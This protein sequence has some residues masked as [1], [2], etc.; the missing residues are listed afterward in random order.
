MVT[1]VNRAQMTTSTVGTGTITLG[2]A[3]DGF[4]SF[5]SAGVSD[6]DTVR[7]TI[8]DGS[9]WEIG[10]G[11]Y[12]ASGTT[13]TRVV[14]E[15]SNSGAAI[16]LSG[17]AVVF[18]TATAEDFTPS[19]TRDFVASGTLSDG[20]SVVVNTDGTVSV[21]SADAVSDTEV[22][23]AV[24]YQ[25]GM[26]MDTSAAFDPVNQKVVI[27]YQNSSNSL[28]G[29]AV[30]GTVSGNTISFGTP[31]VFETG[32]IFYTAICYDAGSGK[33]VIAYRN[34]SNSNYGTAIV[35]TVSGT[36]IS[37]GTAVVFESASTYDPCIV[38]DPDTTNVVI[39]YRDGGNSNYGTAIVGT[40]S[41]TSISFGTAAVFSSTASYTYN[42]G[43]TY[44]TN[45]NKVLITYRDA[46]NSYY[47][48][49][50]VGTVS[51]TSITFGTPVVFESANTAYPSVTYDTVNQKV[52][53]AARSTLNDG[54]AFVGTISGTSVTY[55]SGVK[56]SG[57][58]SSYP[59]IVYDASV[60]KVTIT[61]FDSITSN[62]THAVAGTVS[63]TS[64]SF[65][66]R[67]IADTAGGS[68]I[69]SCY[70]SIN[71]RVVSAFYNAVSMSGDAV[72][73]N[74]V[75]GTNLT[76]TNFIGVSSG[77]YTNGQTAKIQII[78][79]V[80][81]AQSGLTAGQAY[82]VQTDGTLS[83]TPDSPSVFAGTAI[84]ATEIVVKG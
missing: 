51:G 39:G 60:G 73:I 9:N 69:A 12:T 52:V 24:T 41:G 18:V 61:Y 47:G 26:A 34:G 59:C 10:T 20:S 80:D 17:D 19:T 35:G 50:V 62:Y 54:Y 29:T 53:I 30:V 57:N 1:L 84:S 67:V 71:N 13:L 8:E 27:A 77:A 3:S 23:S 37:F 75:V 7:Y 65:D 72:V 28:R 32:F 55:G 22:G 40:V 82:Y 79:A 49:S 76:G 14:D 46:A 56:Y 6:G 38:Y 16:S 21:I 45:Q 48:T 83:T 58:D 42:S 4:Q 36:S 63:G 64:I 78:G 33:V 66:T 81:D 44:D 68:D 25:A 5:A 11:V 31:V 2:G 70:D 43:I 15:S 74:N